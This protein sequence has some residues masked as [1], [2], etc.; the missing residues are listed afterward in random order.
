MLGRETLFVNNIYIMHTKTK[1]SMFVAFWL[2]YS[3][4]AP[5][6]LVFIFIQ[7]ANFIIF[8]AKILY[9]D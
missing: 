1:V 3:I 2:R 7:F 4:V 6:F 5:I 8:I 9:C